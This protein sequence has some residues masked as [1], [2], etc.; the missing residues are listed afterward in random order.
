MQQYAT[1]VLLAIKNGVWSWLKTNLSSFVAGG[2]AATLMDTS[3]DAPEPK[4]V[5]ITVTE[6]AQPLEKNIDI[7]NIIIVTVMILAFT[8]LG[9]VLV[10][11]LNMLK[12]LTKKQNDIEMQTPPNTRRNS[13]YE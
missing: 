3:R 13:G 10:Y 7:F 8:V 4:V 11:V 1:P 12:K 2:A 9:I 5:V 6:K